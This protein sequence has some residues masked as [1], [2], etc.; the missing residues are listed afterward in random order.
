M[1]SLLS[2]VGSDILGHFVFN[3][4]IPLWIY[5]THTYHWAYNV[6][7]AVLSSGERERE[8]IPSLCLQGAHNLVEETCTDTC[9]LDSNKNNMHI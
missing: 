6:S 8:K 3:F 1:F 5:L 7:G 9:N 2:E 4:F